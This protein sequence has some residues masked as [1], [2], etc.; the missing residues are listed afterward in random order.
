MTTGGA[1]AKR[2]QSSVDGG[3]TALWVCIARP[4]NLSEPRIAG[5]LVEVNGLVQHE[6]MRRARASVRTQLEKP[7]AST[8]HACHQICNVRRMLEVKHQ[9]VD[10]N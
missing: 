10:G 5:E 3:V 8:H 9:R 2:L 6:L 7:M 1:T 4:L